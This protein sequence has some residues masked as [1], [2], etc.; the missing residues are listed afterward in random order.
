MQTLSAKWKFESCD[1]VIDEIVKYAAT[2][3]IKTKTNI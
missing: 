1:F 3:E 2:F